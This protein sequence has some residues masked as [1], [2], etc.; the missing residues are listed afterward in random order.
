LRLKGWF[1][2]KDE[3]LTCPEGYQK[4]PKTHPEDH[5]D[6]EAK[7]DTDQADLLSNPSR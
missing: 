2:T 4:K 3:H 5:E 7:A 1:R 6:A